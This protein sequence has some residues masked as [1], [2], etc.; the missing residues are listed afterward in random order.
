MAILVLSSAHQHTCTVPCQCTPQPPDDSCISHNMHGSFLETTWCGSG[1]WVGWW[2]WWWWWWEDGSAVWRG[3]DC[4]PERDAWQSPAKSSTL[5]CSTLAAT[6]GPEMASRDCPAAPRQWSQ[7][8][9]ARP[10]TVHCTEQEESLHSLRFIAH[11]RQGH[12]S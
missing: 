4:L 7:T 8:A 10:P 5:R 9:T 3:R 11:A 1:R 6:C 2:W 12:P